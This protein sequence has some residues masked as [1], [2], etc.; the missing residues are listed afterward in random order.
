V[1]GV[2]ASEA[3]PVSDGVVLFG[4][5]LLR[6]L[7]VE[8]EAVDAVVAIDDVEAVPV[9][10]FLWRLIVEAGVAVVAVESIEGAFEGMGVGV[11]RAAAKMTR[12]L[13][14]IVETVRT[15]R[16]ARRLPT[17]RAR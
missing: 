11:C 15:R 1:E 14:L 4:I 8:L 13:I 5:F 6:F 3:V 17:S 2:G 7:D 16:F 12:G 9:R 10:G